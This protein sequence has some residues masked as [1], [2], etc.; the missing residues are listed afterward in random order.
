MVAVASAASVCVPI[1]CDM[2][3]AS[4]PTAP[5]PRRFTARPRVAR[6]SAHTQLAL[7]PF[8]RTD[9]AD[10][11]TGIPD[12]WVRLVREID[13]AFDQWIQRYAA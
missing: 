5:P 6:L 8:L 10:N 9:S 4:R 11:F 1:L 7:P 3:T 12:E 2:S 13:R